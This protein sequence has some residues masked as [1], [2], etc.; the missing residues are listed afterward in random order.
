MIKNGGFFLG[1]TKSKQKVG[2]SVISTLRLRRDL[3][4]CCLEYYQ[5]ALW[6]RHRSGHGQAR[7]TFSFKVIPLRVFESQFRN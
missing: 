4:G 3:V 1:G 5:F 6:G 2:R 7:A